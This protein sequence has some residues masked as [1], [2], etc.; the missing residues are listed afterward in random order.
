MNYADSRIHPPPTFGS[1][2]NL[3]ALAI[4]ANRYHVEDGDSSMSET[5]YFP[6]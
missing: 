3:E 1:S 2:P 6:R 5:P 4:Q